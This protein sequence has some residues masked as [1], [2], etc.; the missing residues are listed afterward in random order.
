MAPR[1]DAFV[2]GMCSVTLRAQSIPEVATAAADAGLAAIEWG[3]DVHVPAGDVEAA[4]EARRCCADLGLSIVSYGSYLFCTTDVAVEVEPVLDTTEALGTTTVR[5][6]CPFGIEP[7]AAGTATRPDESGSKDDDRAAVVDAVA[8]L[9]AAAADRGIDVYLEFHGGTLT[10][11]GGVGRRPARSGRRPQPLQRLAAAVLGSAADSTPTAT[12][13]ARIGSRLAHL[14]VYEW[15]PDGR[16]H[17]LV[18]G[19]GAWPD[20]LATAASAARPSGFRPRAA[21]LEFVADDDLVALAA[22]AT[23]L[24]GWLA[25]VPSEEGP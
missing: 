18:D 13:C 6:W 19:A 16:R 11:V 23:T 17:P 5:A 12:I 8:T 4:T 22:D 1:P 21:L 15:D 3:G 10:G 2:A 20:R 25:G 14:H 7:H 9:A 24:R